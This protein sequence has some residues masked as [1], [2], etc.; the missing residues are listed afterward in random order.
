MITSFD[1][2]SWSISL[3]WQFYLVAPFL[4][5]LTELRKA[6]WNYFLVLITVAAALVAR[7]FPGYIELGAF[8]PYH[9]K[10]FFVGAASQRIYRAFSINETFGS[11]WKN[12]VARFAPVLLALLVMFFREIGRAACPLLVWFG[13]FSIILSRKTSADSPLASM[14]SRILCYPF[15]QWLGKIS[16]STYL[17]HWLVIVSSSSLLAVSAREASQRN[18]CLLLFL[19][20]FPLV[21]LVSA[22]TFYLIE[23]PGIRVGN[24]VARWIRK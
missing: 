19:V 24:R 9:L 8:L 23:A 17:V 13:V 11:L 3:E 21:L 18:Y 2:P 6:K 14:G 12:H 5:I 20:V 15:L 22:I 1:G 16:Y 10:Y 4:F 7:K